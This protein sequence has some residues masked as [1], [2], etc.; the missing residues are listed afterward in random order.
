MVRTLFV[1]ALLGLVLA[2][3]R[4]QM[5]GKA[6][7]FHNLGVL[8]LGVDVSGATLVVRR[9]D[10]GGPAAQAGLKPGDV[11]AS[12]A[13][14]PLAAAPAPAGPLSRHAE[15]PGVPSILQVVAEVDRCEGEKK[16][17]PV[18]L[19]VRKGGSG[20]ETPVEVT[21]GKAP[22]HAKTC[23]EKCK[24]CQGIVEAGLAFLAKSQRGDGCFPTELGGK[25]GL[26]V[27]TSL[28]GLAFLSAGAPVDGPLERAT[29]YVLNH[30]G[31]A[32]ASPFGR[33][34]GG[35]WNQENWELGYGLMFLA[36]MAKKTRRPDLKAKCAELVGLLEKNQEGSGGWAHGPGGPNALGYLELEI[37]SNYALAGLGA[38]K[39]LG[40]DIDGDRVA[41]AFAWIEQTASADGGVGYSPRPGQKG[42]GDPGRTGGAIVAFA[43]LGQTKHP[44][45]GKMAGYL[46]NHLAGLPGGHVSPCMH[47]LSGAMA[48]RVLKAPWKDYMETYR[49]PIMAARRIDG[50]FASMPTQESQSLRSNTDLTVG[51][52]WTTATYVLI[53]SLPGDR[54]PLLLGGD[55][56][57]EPAPRRGPRTGG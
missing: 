9:V 34:G 7:D 44:F 13:G 1:A 12:V 41:K 4:A 14:K 31:K 26:V 55:G 56:G 6:E 15:G 11:I 8:G 28:G 43:A 39:R 22:A 35:N 52:C 37:V 40:L 36:E 5:P 32:E 48:S 42:N 16:K 30:C 47:L 38:A 50:S 53:L 27:V 51:P 23:P 49:L 17:A 45:F 3:A 19:G 46:G 2:P 21:V 33:A 20:D 54:L 10:A 24:K 57:D 29:N 18:V 25:T